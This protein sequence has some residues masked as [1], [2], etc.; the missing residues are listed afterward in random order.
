MLGERSRAELIG[1]RLDY[2]M[3]SKRELGFVPRKFSHHA[4]TGRQRLAAARVA[5]ENLEWAHQSQ[6]PEP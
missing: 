1:T 4:S 6:A 5:T 3:F 2:E